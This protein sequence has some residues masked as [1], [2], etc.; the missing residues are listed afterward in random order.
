MPPVVRRGGAAGRGEAG[1]QESAA[2]ARQARA[3]VETMFLEIR[4]IRIITLTHACLPF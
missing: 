1:F 3:Q 4:A 2:L